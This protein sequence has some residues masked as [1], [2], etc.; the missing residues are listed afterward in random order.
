[1]LVEGFPRRLEVPSGLSE[2]QKGRGTLH[3]SC[4][5]SILRAKQLDLSSSQR[6]VLHAVY[7][8]W[9][10]VQ[11]EKWVV[12]LSTCLGCCFPALQSLPFLTWVTCWSLTKAQNSRC[13][14]EHHGQHWS[15]P[16]LVCKSV[17]SVQQGS[18]LMMTQKKNVINI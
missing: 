14:A 17:C 10:G 11:S 7:Y 18:G 5:C 12:C 2:K 8:L 13:L 9:A 4:I 3:I 15:L 1:M 6:F 16:R